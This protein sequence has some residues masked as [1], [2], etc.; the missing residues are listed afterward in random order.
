MKVIQWFSCLLG[1][2][3]GILP[4]RL[5]TPTALHVH[6]SVMRVRHAPLVS[7][8]CPVSCDPCAVCRRLGEALSVRSLPQRHYELAVLR[9]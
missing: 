8:C 3:V 7:L 2:A 5:P 9:V 1:K 6:R 4:L